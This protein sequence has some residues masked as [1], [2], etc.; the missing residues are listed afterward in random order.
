MPKTGNKFNDLF[1]LGKIMA[2]QKKDQQGKT[3]EEYEFEK[4]ARE[5][6]FKP[7]INSSSNKMALRNKSPNA[8]QESEGIVANIK[9]TQKQIERLK[10][11]RERQE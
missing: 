8:G 2:S 4:A 6:T 5:C 7:Q 3:T 9:G 1:S 10:A 11:A